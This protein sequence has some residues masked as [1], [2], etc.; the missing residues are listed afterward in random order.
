MSIPPR[1]NLTAALSAAGAGD[2][3]AADRLLPQVY[4]QLRALAQKHMSGERPDHTLQAT[5]VVHEAYV[6]LID[7][8]RV[9]WRDRNHFFAVAASMIRRILVDYARA[10]CAAKRGGDRETVTLHEELDWSGGRALDLIDLDDALQQLAAL[11]ERQARVVELR[12]FGGLSI[13][14]AAEAIGVSTTTVENEWAVARAW[15]RR[16]L[17]GN[18]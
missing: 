6:R 18:G 7:Q 4:D 16:A 11:D 13:S 10:R 2:P 5:A 14:E 1:E 15:L 3:A 17:E 12:F 9:E 8:T